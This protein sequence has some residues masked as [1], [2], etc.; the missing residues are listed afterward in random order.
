MVRYEFDNTLE[1]STNF[2]TSQSG[3]WLVHSEERSHAVS[4]YRASQYIA[5]CMTSIRCLII[6]LFTRYNLWV[7]GQNN[8]T[9]IVPDVIS[10]VQISYGIRIYVRAILIALWVDDTCNNYPLLVKVGK[11]YATPGTACWYFVDK[12]WTDFNI[13]LELSVVV[14][15][16]STFYRQRSVFKVLRRPKRIKRSVGQLLNKVNQNKTMIHNGF[17]HIQVKS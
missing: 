14:P 17:K 6:S 10:K 15:V 3:F 5:L 9:L 13:T 4:I 7:D 2:W 12:S 11:R 8:A 1:V 16:R